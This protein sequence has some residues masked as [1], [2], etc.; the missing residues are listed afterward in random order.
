MSDILKGLKEISLDKL[1]VTGGKEL[2]ITSCFTSGDQIEFVMEA[3]A[4]SYLGSRY[5]TERKEL[6]ERLTCSYGGRHRTDVV[7]IGKSNTIGEM[8]VLPFNGVD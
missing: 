5:I 8:P 1:S 4:H 7:D 6:L 2:D 3:M